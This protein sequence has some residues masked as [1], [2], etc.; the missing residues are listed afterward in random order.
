MKTRFLYVDQQQQSMGQ[1]TITPK[2]I[3]GTEPIFNIFKY[4]SQEGDE[5]IKGQ[6]A[7]QK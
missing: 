7:E 5:A 1:D 4:N 3:P 6:N 2:F